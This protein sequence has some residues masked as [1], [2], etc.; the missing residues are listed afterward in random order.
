M[1][2]AYLRLRDH[3]TALGHFNKAAQDFAKHKSPRAS[4]LVEGDRREL[5]PGLPRHRGGE[6]NWSGGDAESDDDNVANPAFEASL[7]YHRSVSEYLT[8]VRGWS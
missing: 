6:G 3:H 2:L 5:S 1:G 4:K 7:H 8:R